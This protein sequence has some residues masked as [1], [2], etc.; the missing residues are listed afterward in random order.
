MQIA[1]VHGADT[2]LP[3]FLA[4]LQAADL[5]VRLF[6]DLVDFQRIARR[7]TFDLVLLDAGLAADRLASLIAELRAGPLAKAAILLV[8]GP[9]HAEAAAAGLYAGADDFLPT[10]TPPDLLKAKLVAAWRRT[11]PD[12]HERPAWRA[13]PYEI[14]WQARTVARRGR[15]IGLTRKE[16]AL[17]E[18]LLSAAG[19]PL[20]RSYL[21]D[22]VWGPQRDHDTRTLDAHV[23]RLRNKLALR[24]ETALRLTPV[25]GYGYQLDVVAGA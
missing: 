17:L 7:E 25:Y 1:M 9:G 20:S 10:S 12:P 13:G 8:A 14:D 22:M 24:A 15:R 18:T 19:R 4:T 11:A 6:A 5:P 21:L 3:A 16:F 23:Y 2:E